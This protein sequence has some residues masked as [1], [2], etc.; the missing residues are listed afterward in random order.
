MKTR[1]LFQLAAPFFGALMLNPFVPMKRRFEFS[2]SLLRA[3]C[4]RCDLAGRFAFGERVNSHSGVGAR[5]RV[6]GFVRGN[7]SRAEC[8]VAYWTQTDPDFFLGLP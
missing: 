6:L 4:L 5:E 3:S 2:P 8:I 7:A 1:G